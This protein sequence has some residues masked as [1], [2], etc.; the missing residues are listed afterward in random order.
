[1]HSISYQSPTVL[2]LFSD[3][4]QDQ[5]G[6]KENRKFM[7]KK[8]KELLTNICGKSISEQQKILDTAFED[9]KGKN[10]Q[11]DDVMVIG[12]SL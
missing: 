6:G 12:I 7:V 5:F 11:I 2:Y 4:Y 3:G 9:W 8:L 1:M 10:K